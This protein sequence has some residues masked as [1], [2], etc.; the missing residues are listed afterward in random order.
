[1]D[2]LLVNAR[3]KNVTEHSQLS[4]P[5]GLAYLG[6]YL[7][8]AGY[9]V[10]ALD[11]NIIPWENNQIINII[12]K[13]EPRIVAV[14]VYTPTYLNGLAFARLVKQVSPGTKVI[15]GGAHASVLYREVAGEKD[16]D[17][18]V[19]G[20]GE[21]SML[22][23]AE[24]FIG[25]KGSLANIKSIAYK[26]NGNI[27]VTEKRMPIE[28]PDTLPFPDRQL[29][30][31]HLYDI[32]NAVLAS[33]GGCPFFCHFCAVNN[34][35]DGKRRF[36]EG[37]RIVDE[38]L[39]VI[40][41]FGIQ[42]AGRVSFSDDTFT[43]DRKRVIELCRLMQNYLGVL[44][45]RCSTRVDLVD[46]EILAEMRRAGCCQILYGVE[47]GSQSILDS[48]SKK[49]TLENIKRAVEE[50]VSLGMDAACSFMFPH[51]EDTEETI[52]EQIHFMRDLHEM[53]ASEVLSM[54]TPLPGT[55]LY[56]N[57]DKLGIKILSKNWDDY[58]CW[59][60]VIET[61]NFSNEKLDYLHRE[62]VDRVGMQ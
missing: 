40:N 54:T 62:I 58:D 25:N 46:A 6:S 28:D 23:L 59:H 60:I 29:F 2:V 56:E 52:N 51:P 7:Q 22:E 26:D 39:G 33:R 14:S 8:N 36:R 44:P 53:G 15:F 3:L 27:R 50:T 48:I 13:L 34:I 32:P 61:K 41:T 38:I 12:N 49:I 30:P 35:W 42:K 57:A 20:E 19:R 5:L 21:Y 16:V 55:Y 4:L 18:V 43:L 1:M 37:T 45:W 17:V 10:S 24:C 11:L 47:T 9:D 31:F